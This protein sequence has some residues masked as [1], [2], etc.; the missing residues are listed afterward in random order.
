MAPF[1]L[2]KCPGQLYVFMFLVGFNLNFVNATIAAVSIDVGID[3]SIHMTE[4][5]RQGIVRNPDSSKLEN[6]RTAV[7]R[8][9]MAL[10]GST[11]SS[12]LVLVRSAW[13]PCLSY[14]LTGFSLP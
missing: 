11:V 10:A 14:L 7:T 9:G 5:Y 1:G 13:H 6:L 3:F 12:K 8:T 2:R 4:G